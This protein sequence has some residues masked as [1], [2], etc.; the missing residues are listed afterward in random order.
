MFRKTTILLS[1]VMVLGTAL[2]ASAA[3]KS[4]LSGAGGSA[5]YTMIPGYAKDGSVIV[6]P[7]PDHSGQ[8]QLTGDENPLR[9]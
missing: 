9:H 5:F 7:D 4:Q 6:L 3:P 8:V 2:S 1:A